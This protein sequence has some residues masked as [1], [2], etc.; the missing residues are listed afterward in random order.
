MIPRAG[1]VALALLRI[2]AGVS[3]VAAGLHKVGWLMHPALEPI[4]TSWAAHPANSLVARYLAGVTPHHLVF[5][6]LVAVGELGLGALLVAGLLTPVAG[7]LAFLMVANFHFASSAMFHGDYFTG[8]TGVLYL[9]VLPTLALC[10]AGTALGLDGMLAG[11]GGGR[12]A[13]AK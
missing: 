5:A 6:R 3:L 2:A 12:S 11:G 4:L 9:L 13:P 7:I 8:A 1:V 10:R